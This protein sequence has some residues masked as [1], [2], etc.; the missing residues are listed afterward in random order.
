MGVCYHETFSIG[1]QE[2]EGGVIR[3]CAT[4]GNTFVRPTAVKPHIYIE[5]GF[6]R[7]KSV[8]YSRN[9]RTNFLK[10][11]QFIAKLNSSRSVKNA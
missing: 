11:Y 3:R 10:A 4:C 1:L 7:I 6:W 5:Q 8:G 2:V 9:D